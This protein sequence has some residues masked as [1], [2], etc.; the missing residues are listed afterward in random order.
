MLTEHISEDYFSSEFS[1]VLLLAE[2]FQ[3]WSQGRKHISYRWYVCRYE[4]IIL[5]F[6]KSNHDDQ[7]KTPY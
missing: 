6:L 5:I 1:L 2:I 4:L 7:A 3:K